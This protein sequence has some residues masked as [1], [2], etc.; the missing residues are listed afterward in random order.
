MGD[1]RTHVIFG[2]DAKK[3][4]LDGMNTAASAV[5]CTMGPKG[6]TV[7][8]QT[9]DDA[10]PIITKDGVTV[11]KSL[12]LTDPV[13]RLGANLIR[14]AASRTNDTAGDGTTTATVLTHAMARKI[15][16]LM[17]AGHSVVSIRDGIE[18]AVEEATNILRDMSTNIDSIDA[19]KQVGTISAN[20]DTNIG[21]IIGNAMA[22]VGRDG[23]ITVE[24]AKGTA[25]TLDVIDGMQF[26][27]GYLSPYFITN[28]ERASAVYT[29]VRVLITTQKLSSIKELVPVLEAVHRASVPLLIIADDVEGDA[30][31][32]LVLN[33]SKSNLKVVAV[34]SPGF[35]P[36]RN[37]ILGD[38][39]VLTGTKLV[40]PA[41]G[42]TLDQIKFEDLGRAKKIICDAKS[43]TVI[44]A[45]GNE[46]VDA[47]IAE[48]RSQ[49]D[50]PT[51]T[52]D[53]VSL[54]KVRL[55]KLG[56]GVAII[57]VGGAT[58]VEMIERKHRIED[59]L[60]ATRAA[61]EEGIVPGGG[62]ALVRVA[63]LLKGSDDDTDVG[64]DVV[65]TACLEPIRRIVENAGGS[66]DVVL[67]KVN[68]SDRKLGY[69]ARSDKFVDMLEVGIIDPV[70]VT[71]CAL[72]NAASV[73]VAF[74]S[75][76]AVVYSDD[77]VPAK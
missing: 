13:H 6:Q 63:A 76:N 18:R 71:R 65:R 41:T 28:A 64:Y 44:C 47:R 2:N 31:Q 10:P 9:S 55:A 38:L 33:K 16:K 46:K 43:T 11:S 48:L 17:S 42:T 68:D 66:P 69:D 4:L 58:E 51:L 20:G 56:S 74:A 39:C 21:D 19:I 1:R 34:K 12:V 7:I 62:T 45:G 14:E 23:I 24:D 26:D 49:L 59:A 73:A 29:D 5:A 77:E 70:K 25:T 52:T 37:E 15:M 54:L 35:G 50:N 53:E 22:K 75:L 57:K 40:S 36:M 32:G 61:A 8:I 72:Q 67:A 60:H 30:L 3:R 27:R